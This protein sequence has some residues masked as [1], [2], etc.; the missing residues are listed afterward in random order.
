MDDEYMT[1]AELIEELQRYTPTA[2]IGVRASCCCHAHPFEV[3]L[4]SGNDGEEN[5]P[6]IIDAR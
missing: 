6:I 2:K 1:V 4:A 5:T 3:R